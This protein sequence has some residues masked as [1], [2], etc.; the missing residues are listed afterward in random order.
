MN[1]VDCVYDKLV[2]NTAVFAYLSF[3]KPRFMYL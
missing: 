1:V 2:L 3:M